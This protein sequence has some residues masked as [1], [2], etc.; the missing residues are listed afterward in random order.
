MAPT[1]KI[2]TKVFLKKLTSNTLVVLQ[3][4]D[5]AT[6]AKLVQ[7]ANY[8]YYNTREPLFSDTTYDIVHDYLQQIDPSNPV[9]KQIG[10]QIPNMDNR[11]EDLPFY[12]GSL[13]KI[14]NN[15]PESLDK[16]KRKFIGSHVVS[17]KLDG[18]SAL[19]HVKDGNVKLYSRGDGKIGQNITSILPYI[20][21][22]PKHLVEDANKQKNKTLAIRGELIISKE[23]FAKVAD[24]GANARNMVAGV[25]NAKMPDLDVLSLV[26][27]VAYELLYPNGMTIS[28][29]LDS[30]KCAGFY[31]VNHKLLSDKQLSEDYLSDILSERRSVSPFEIDGV[32]VF[33]NGK[34]HK[35]AVNE[36]PEYA[37]AFKSIN[38]MGK[39][40]VIV[41]HVEWN[42]SKDGYMIPVVNFTPVAL[43]GVV[44]QRAHGFNGKYIYDHKIGPCS[45]LLIMR[46]GQVI[47]Y[48]HEVLS[49]SETGEPQMPEASYTW[50]K[51]GVDII[52]N[53]NYDLEAK[54]LEYFFEKID[55]PGLSGATVKKMYESGL[56]TPQQIFTAKIQDLLKV[57]GFK[58]KM[59]QKTFDALQKRKIE[60]ADVSACTLLMDASNTL[61]RGIGTKKLNLITEHIPKILSDKYIPTLAELTTIKGVETKTATQIIQNLP[62]CFKF[63]DDNGFNFC[64]KQP[65]DAKNGPIS[66]ASMKLK[67][68]II[69]F[70][71]VRSKE[72]EAYIVAN[73][74]TIASSVNKK[75]TVLITKS[76][77]SDSSSMK[78]AKE[79]GIKIMTL[80][81]FLRTH[82]I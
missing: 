18:N 82:A 57:H 69:V 1:K 56:T 55:V 49:P 35:H 38:A 51:T 45:R 70:T 9:L 58:D 71:G 40:E 4:L 2:A 17:D 42:M 41:T 36:N 28:E 79:L 60:L 50:S 16:F 7:E 80:D 72:A 48:I 19:L 39:A 37:F 23:N 77:E 46:S 13:D 21:E 24:K 74:G 8:A 11:K 76:L 78:K 43:D 6:I 81:E 67:D 33:H 27:F 15:D 65:Q 64:L 34:A 59:A 62:K 52:A 32:V 68:E 44:I 30:M 73:S 54:T 66:P 3:G 75:T 53:E 29:Q 31:V 61:G 47:P 5:K 12:M 10:S 20:Q 22:I 14:K 25:I 26:Q 63:L